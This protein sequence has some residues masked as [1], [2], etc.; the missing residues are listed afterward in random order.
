MI[1]LD[2]RTRT[3]DQTPEDLQTIGRL[4]LELG[5][6]LNI[7]AKPEAVA[8]VGMWLFDVPVKK[9]PGGDDKGRIDCQLAGLRELKSFPQ[10]LVLVGRSS[11]RIK[12]L[13]VQ[14]HG[15][16]VERCVA[17]GAHRASCPVQRVFLLGQRYLWW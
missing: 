13:N 16:P 9:F 1:A 17:V 6:E 4:F 7:D 2:E 5:V 10:D 12:G 15:N 11:I 3:G 14:A 8:A